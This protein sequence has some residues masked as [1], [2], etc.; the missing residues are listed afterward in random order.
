[1]GSRAAIPTLSEW[2]IGMLAALL[3]IVGFAAMRRQAR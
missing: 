1:M 2:A 3:A